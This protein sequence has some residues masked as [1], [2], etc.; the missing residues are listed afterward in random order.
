MHSHTNSHTPTPCSHTQTA[1]VKCWQIERQGQIRSLFYWWKL[2]IRWARH[3][4]TLCVCIYAFV[5]WCASFCVCWFSY[6]I[7]GANSHHKVSK[8]ELDLHWKPMSSTWLLHLAPLNCS[9]TS[10]FI[11]GLSV[12]VFKNWSLHKV[13]WPLLI[14]G[15]LASTGPWERPEYCHSHTCLKLPQTLKHP[16]KYY[17]GQHL[18]Y[19][20]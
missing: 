1:T 20:Q 5:C 7:R 15:K 9:S 17:S 13:S 3:T 18:G 14:D 12:S 11:P 4:F 16:W 8:L 2:P 6:A 10:S 19:E